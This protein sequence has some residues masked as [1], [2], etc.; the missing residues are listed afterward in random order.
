[1]AWV[2]QTF[3][4]G[5]L[6]R[7][8][9]G[10]GTASAL[11]L[12]SYEPDFLSMADP[13]NEAEEAFIESRL[14]EGYYQKLGWNKGT[15]GAPEVQEAV[16]R[17]WMEQGARGVIW[18]LARVHD[19]HSVDVLAAV[20]EI[21]GDVGRED[22][23][24]MKACLDVLDHLPSEE[25]EDVALTALRWM[26]TPSDLSLRDRLRASIDRYLRHA[27]MEIQEK[28]VLAAR[29]L[30]DGVAE[31]LFVAVYEDVNEA[32]RGVIDEESVYRVLRS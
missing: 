21:A 28:A 26:T 31:A 8:R 9:N 4:T 32:T 23:A 30:P 16:R 15:A 13:A 24:G 17:F 19:E 7:W 27:D 20:A 3:Q 1:M 2:N 14:R 29:A 25:Q 22:P 18:L 11:P 12:T 6:G 10:Y 5:G